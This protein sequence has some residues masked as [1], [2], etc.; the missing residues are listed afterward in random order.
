MVTQRRKRRTRPRDYHPEVE[1][2]EAYKEWLNRLLLD[3]KRRHRYEDESR[4]ARR[5]AMVCDYRFIGK[6][7]QAEVEAGFDIWTAR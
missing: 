5:L 6:E 1:R 7:A 2:F 3:V 4:I